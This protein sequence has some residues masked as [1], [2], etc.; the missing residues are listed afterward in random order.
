MAAL[1]YQENEISSDIHPQAG[2]TGTDRRLS[3]QPTLQLTHFTMKGQL[4][5]GR[6]VS[7]LAYAI[8][9]EMGLSDQQ[10]HDLVIAGFFHDIGK[11]DMAKGYDDS[12]PTMFVEEIMS[13]RHHPVA[14]FQILKRHGYNEEICRSVLYHHENADGTGYPE[15]LS[16][17]QIPIGACILRVSDIYCNLVSDR[18]YRTAFTPEDAL[19]MVI[20]QIKAL[21]ISVFLAFQ[22]VIHDEEGN[23]RMPETPPEVR[24]IWR[25]L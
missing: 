23:I 5:H 12:T 22:R 24:R 17:S 4:E 2:K 10:C 15:R 3:Y 9:R 16:G 8:G 6:M 18:P 14:S 20:E 21:N 19:E 11:T 13:I 7:S 1:H 25:T